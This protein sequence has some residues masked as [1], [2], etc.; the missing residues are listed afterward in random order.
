MSVA[1]K[2]ALHLRLDRHEG[3]S[4]PKP[5]KILLL[6]HYPMRSSASLQ[7]KGMMPWAARTPTT[8]SPDS[9]AQTFFASRLASSSPIV[10]PHLRHLLA[11]ACRPKPS[12]G[13]RPRPSS[14]SPSHPLGEGKKT[15][16]PHPRTQSLISLEAAGDQPFYRRARRHPSVSSAVIHPVAENQPPSHPRQRDHG[17]A[18][19]S[20]WSFPT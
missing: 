16:D 1:A 2:Q 14:D 13:D 20:A 11:V 18:S 10:H 15:G 19:A 7:R 12:P 3:R 5:G 9:I 8:G 17:R 6:H 4:H